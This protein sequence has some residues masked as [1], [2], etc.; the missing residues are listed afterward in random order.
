MLDE[1]SNK[2]YLPICLNLNNKNVVIFG[3]GR[4]AY[5]KA[6]ILSKYGAN[7]NV[8]AKEFFKGFYKLKNIT[9][10]QKEIDI[11]DLKSNYSFVVCALND[12][13]LNKKIY[14]FY[15][16]KNIPINVVD[17]PHLCNCIF[18][19][20]LEQ[21]DISIAI[22]TN[23]KMAGFSRYLKLC[24]KRWLRKDA[25]KILEE[26]SLMR[27]KLKEKIP[28]V[29]KRIRIVRKVLKQYDFLG[30]KQGSRSFKDI[31]NLIKTAFSPYI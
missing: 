29:T 9:L 7:I 17:Q 26:L 27:S 31:K 1:S 24:I 23:G 16:N 10:I 25:Y 4:I 15:A 22:S 5:Q 30:E 19:A 12:S 11:K 28:S 3:G 8:I 14:D 18:P 13:K 6:K 21:K 2:K 20:I